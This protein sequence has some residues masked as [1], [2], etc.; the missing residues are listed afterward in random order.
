MKI[1]PNFVHLGLR[2]HPLAELSHR[3]ATLYVMIEHLK[4]D[5]FEL[6]G[7]PSVKCTL[8]PRALV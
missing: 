5:Q 3:V 7:T 4:C 6:R 8:N 1:Y 2:F